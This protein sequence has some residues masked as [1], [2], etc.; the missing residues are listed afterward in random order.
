MSGSAF[1]ASMTLD[2]AYQLALAKDA[3]LAASQAQLDASKELTEQAFAQLLPQ[4]NVSAS[5]KK[6]QYQLPNNT[7]SFDENTNNK[8]LQVTQALYN[9][10]A[11]YALEQAGLKVDYSRLRLSGANNE[12][13]VRV[14]QAYLNVLLTQENLLISEQQ[15]NATEKR[16]EQVSAALKVGYSTKVDKLSLQ[17]ELDDAKA[18]LTSDQQQLIFFRQ[19][20]KVFIGQDITTSLPWPK[21]NAQALVN[22]FVRS[23]SWLEEAQN[24]NID[25]QLQQKA[26]EVAQ[27]EIAIRQSAFYPTVNLGGYYSDASGASY[28]AQK[29]DNKA[30]YIEVKMPLYQG[31][32]DSARVRES[33]SLL[34]AAEYD[35]QYAKRDA[36]Q[37][38]QEQISAA[39]ASVE[40]LEALKQA[41]ESGESYLD[42]VEEGYRLG[43]R[44]I[45]ELSRAKEKLYANRRDHIRASVEL[46]NALTLL[47]AV[48]G[49]L[50]AQAM[51]QL[52]QAVW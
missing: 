34:R 39:N 15:V 19:K 30:V 51:K 41:I 16:L 1:A 26:V 9:R 7:L 14:T 21:V 4:I 32:Y 48:S 8:N 11:L 10:Q 29:N 25:V 18:K 36:T 13:G 2:E 43:I 49:Q 27:Q 42:S 20:L 12:L 33:Q 46:L 37:Q 31:G 47:H 5:V 28:F 50:D 45:T 40:K 6:E 44:D 24:N 23:K 22:Q 3:K 38:A 52:S 17:A 35:A